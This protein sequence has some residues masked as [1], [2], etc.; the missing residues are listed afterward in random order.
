MPPMDTGIVKGSIVTDSNLSI[1][2]VENIVK[3]ISNILLTVHYIDRFHRKEDIWTIER[4][5]SKKI[6]EIPDLKYVDIFD[7]GATPLSNIRANLDV[8]ISGDNL[9][10]LDKIAE[11]IK[12]K[13][14]EV[15][16][17]KSVSRTWDYD[18]I[19]TLWKTLNR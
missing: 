12:E 14:Y 6:W 19:L 18:K 11:K 15:K 3:K 16:G 1:H 4:N 17:L 7:Y 10:I 5:L 9:K 13:V 2:Q 8:M